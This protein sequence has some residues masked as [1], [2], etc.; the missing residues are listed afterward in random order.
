MKGILYEYQMNPT[1]WAYLSSL[2]IIGTFFKFR[3]VWSVRNLDLLALLFFTPGLLLVSHDKEQLGYVWLFAVGGFFLVRLL[4]DPVMVRRPLLE[5][6]L[7]AGGL[8][9]T[10]IALLV[11]LMSNVVTGK[12]SSSDLAGAQRSEEIL[13]RSETPPEK[14]GLDKHGPGYPLF[15]IIAS[16]PNKV[17]MP[18]DKT[19]PEQYRR[20]V[21][22]TATTRTTA[23]LAHLAVVLGLVLI[24]YR[25]F[26]NVQTGVATAC[27]YLLLPYTA[28]M[29]GHVDHV[30]P[31][32]LLIWAVEAYRRPMVAG[33]FLGLAAGVIYYPLFL[34]PLWLSFY[35]RRG[36]I[37]FAAGVVV[38]QA[39][40]VASLALTS[41]NF[42]AFWQQVTQM[43][44]WVT[45]DFA[46]FWEYHEPAYRIP[47]LAAFV[48]LCGSMAL[49]P[50]Q[51]NLG[52]LLSCS[53][54]VMLGTQFWLG[55]QGGLY[56]AWYLPLLLLTIFR[57]N[58]EDRVAIT[59]VTERW[60]LRRRPRAASGEKTAGT[61]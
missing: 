33:M 13:A 6:N 40:L 3:R 25:H 26:D 53:A 12:L 29:T 1:T 61:A 38:V 5:P 57:P 56:M 31:A 54:A 60:S 9:F 58:L 18:V 50:A 14:S 8:T 37:R 11:F 41:S 51:K 39:L 24:G 59:A 7:N 16:F 19:D 32:A 27:L 2:L 36:L 52:T 42:Q 47:V 10:G 15:Y 45:K 49:W 46:G 4:L 44:G 35:W 20:A 48:A 30:V 22:Q 23:I 21:V 28:Q 43:F 55:N 17:L 34:L